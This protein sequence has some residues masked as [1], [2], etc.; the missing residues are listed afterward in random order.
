M[1]DNRF[2]ENYFDEVFKEIIVTTW[3]LLSKYGGTS[4]Q[5]QTKKIGCWE[6]VQNN[7]D[8]YDKIKDRYQSLQLR[9]RAR[10]EIDAAFSDPMEKAI[11]CLSILFTN[12]MVRGELL[13]YGRFKRIVPKIDNGDDISFDLVLS[14]LDRVAVDLD[15]TI[16]DKVKAEFSREFSDLK[17]SYVTTG[18]IDT[19]VV[20]QLLQ[21][22]SE[23]SKY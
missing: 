2:E 8:R 21:R 6:Y 10:H 3:S 4:V 18:L 11:C 7:I 19:G 9:K 23:E 12:E 14:A 5:E 20:R 1:F 17:N 13:S 16:V 22:A 15:F